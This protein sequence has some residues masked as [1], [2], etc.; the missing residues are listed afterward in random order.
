MRARPALTPGGAGTAGGS[1]VNES[2]AV[3]YQTQ[4]EGVTGWVH[5]G[6]LSGDVAAGDLGVVEV[7]L[8]DQSAGL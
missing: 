2:G 6:Y 4:V 3:W 5:G 7:D 8:H 1:G